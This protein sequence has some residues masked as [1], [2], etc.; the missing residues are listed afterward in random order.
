MENLNYKNKN[1]EI[2]YLNN[3]Y[4]SL[5]SCL[6][7][8]RAK[9]AGFFKDKGASLFKSNTTKYFGKK[10]WKEKKLRKKKHKNNMKKI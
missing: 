6:S 4:N 1:I 3:W 9:I 2:K 8:S 7:Q 10:S 5:I